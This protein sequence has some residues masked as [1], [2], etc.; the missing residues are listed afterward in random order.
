MYFIRTK[1]YPTGLHATV[2][3][4]YLHRLFV[5]FNVNV[6]IVRINVNITYISPFEKIATNAIIAHA[7]QILVSRSYTRITIS[8]T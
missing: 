4:G 8:A 6:D 3:Y 5:K 2:Y 7:F 1:I